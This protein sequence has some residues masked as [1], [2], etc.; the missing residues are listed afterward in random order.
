M[1]IVATI[2]A[3]M[4][5]SRLP[6]KVMMPIGGQPA[7]ALLIQRLKRV[8]EL[9]EIVL[10]TTTNVADDVLAATAAAVGVQTY[11]GSEDDVLGRV[12]GAIDFGRGEVCVEITADAPL[13][14]P[15]MVSRMIYEFRCTRGRNTYVANTTGPQMGAPHGLD[16][17]IFEADALR[18][19]EAN[20][21]DPA[22]REHVSLP[23]Y[24]DGEESKWRPRFVSF[25][26]HEECRST[27]LSLDYLEDYELICDVH[28]SLIRTVG[29]Y[30]ASDLMS[31]VKRGP[32][33]RAA[34]WRFAVGN[35]AQSRSVGNGAHRFGLRSARRLCD[36]NPSQGNPS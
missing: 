5:S 19:I 8:P 4:T 2:E 13:T 14:D 24:R 7:L 16:V 34:V 18:E 30:S 12:R 25:F 1:R 23:F 10:A 35:G 11:R 26:S 17:Q 15:T 3:R 21:K 31:A 6:G 29:D 36:P 20:C 22:A 33:R 32:S 27:W 28:E 9:D